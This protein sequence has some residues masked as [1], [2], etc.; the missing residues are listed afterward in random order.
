MDD[1]SK[2]WCE[3][4]G[5]NREGGLSLQFEFLG[6][7]SVV[8]EWHCRESGCIDPQPHAF[9]RLRLFVYVVFITSNL[10]LFQKKKKKKLLKEISKLA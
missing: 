6:I 10:R 9:C 3:A 7:L 1:G 8:G 2:G 5:G 4:K